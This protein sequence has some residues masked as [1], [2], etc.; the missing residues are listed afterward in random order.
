M[1]NPGVSKSGS[2]TLRLKTV[3][4]D[5]AISLAIAAMR[6]VPDSL[7]LASLLLIFISTPASAI[8]KKSAEYATPPHD[9]VR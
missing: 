6:A 7:A 2:P 8:L 1:M 5:A 4:P 9:Q 3:F